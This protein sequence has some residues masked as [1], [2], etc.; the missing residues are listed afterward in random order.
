MCANTHTN[1]YTYT[2]ICIYTV[3]ESEKVICLTKEASCIR[4]GIYSFGMLFSYALN[5][6]IIN[7]EVKH[8]IL[9][10]IQ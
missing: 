9:R 2:E 10:S 3:K 6:I 7:E 8:V 4:I 5:K 1:R